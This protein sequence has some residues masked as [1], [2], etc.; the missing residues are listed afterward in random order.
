MYV[1]GTF[2]LAG[3]SEGEK[4]SSKGTENLHTLVGIG[5]PDCILF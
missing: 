3:M 5:L 4:I 2:S 1:P